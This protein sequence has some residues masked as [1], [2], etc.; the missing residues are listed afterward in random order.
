MMKTVFVLCDFS[1]VL[2][3]TKDGVTS[4]HGVDWRRR[5]PDEPGASVIIP[6]RLHHTGD[7]S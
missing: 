7:D 5:G 4:V 3:G 6:D 1:T 2:P